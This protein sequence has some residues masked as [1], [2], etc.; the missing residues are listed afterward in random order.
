MSRPEN[1]LVSIIIPVYN[2]E[3]Y[4]AEAIESA[5]SQTYRPIEIIVIDDGSTDETKRVVERFEND[6]VYRYQINQGSS[7]ARNTGVALANGEYLAFLDADDVWMSE[8]LERQMP[9]LIASSDI[10]LVSSY[11]QQFISPDLSEEEKVNVLL[12]PDEMDGFL[13]TTVVVKK[14]SFERVGPFDTSWTVGEFM[15]WHLR[16]RELGLRFYT[17]EK[18]LARRR[19]HSTNKGILLRSYEYERAQILKASLDRRRAAVK[20]NE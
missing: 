16:A 7:A 12:P 20:K 1:P 11:M 18:L 5:V 19:I 13:A 2:G 6:V 10:D 4:V 9:V 14:S 8:K 17:I 3:R 15:D